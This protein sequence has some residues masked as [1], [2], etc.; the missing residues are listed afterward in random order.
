M[1]VCAELFAKGRARD[2]A[3]RIAASASRSCSSPT[4]SATRCTFRS[5]SA[6]RAIL[7]PGPPAPANVYGVDR[8]AS[9]D[10]VLLGAD[11]LRHAAGARARPEFDLSS[12]PAGGLGRRGAAAG[13]LRAL[14]AALRHRDHRRHRLDRGAPHVHLQSSRRDPA[15]LERADRRRLRRAHPRRRRQPVAAGRDRQPVDPRR[16]DLRRLLE[17]AREDARHHP[18]RLAAHRRQVHAG[19]RRLLLVRRADPTTC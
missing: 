18:G 15:G 4:A 10:A 11:R 2:H 9:A 13:A 8:A 16:L 3:R 12:H 14:Q 1:V 19:R 17:P 7:W 6:R 5:P